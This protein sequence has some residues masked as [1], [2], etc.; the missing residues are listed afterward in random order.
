MDARS[1][2]KMADVLVAVNFG[3]D[4]NASQYMREG[5]SGAEGPGRWTDGDFAAIESG[6]YVGAFERVEFELA[7]DAH[8]FGGGQRVRVT[9]N[10]RDVGSTQIGRDLV[11]QTFKLSAGTIHNGE[12]LRLE[13]HLP[14]AHSPRSVGMSG[15]NRKL[16][17]WVEKLELRKVGRAESEREARVSLNPSNLPVLI[18]FSAAG[19]SIRFTRSGW[20]GQ[21]SKG[22]WTDGD[23]AAVESGPY[24]GAFERLELELAVEANSF[25]GAQ[26]VRVTANGRLVGETQMGRVLMRQTF[27]I[28]AGTIQNG[29]MLRL[30]FHLPDA[31]SPDSKGLSGD[32]RKLG[33]WVEKLELRRV[34]K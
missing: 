12:K 16:G 18:D 6:P 14:D 1:A 26:R 11:R 8:S 19:N 33:L 20:S 2:V 29:G 17:L 23:I 25:G 4:G 24:V 15:D 28:P 7:L 10:G 31:H 34:G 13:F 30:E 22:R 9:A 3:K 27:K 21:E 5:W 32:N